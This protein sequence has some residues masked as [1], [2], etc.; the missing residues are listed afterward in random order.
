[1]VHHLFLGSSWLWSVGALGSDVS[2][3]EFKKAYPN[4]K[5]I[6][7]QAAIERHDDKNL[8]FD[9]G[10]CIEFEISP[11]M[12]VQRLCIQ[13][14]VQILREQNMGLRT[15]WAGLIHIRATHWQHM[16]TSHT[17]THLRSKLGIVSISLHKIAGVDDGLPL[18]T[19][20]A[21][22][23]K[24]SPSSTRLLRPW[25]RPTSCSI[26]LAQN[27][28]LRMIFSADHSLTIIVWC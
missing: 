13:C 27:R 7:P 10:K 20:L 24:M 9:G 2:I 5:L 17:H 23:T 16:L 25:S 28:Y 3:G 15:T 8:K 21:S 11:L 4:A 18:V 6:A 19:S 14:G 12:H 22:R 1:M 26:F